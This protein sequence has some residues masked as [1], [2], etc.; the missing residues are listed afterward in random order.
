MNACSNYDLLTCMSMQERELDS[1][2]RLLWK[3]LAS[4]WQHVVDIY[5]R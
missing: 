4:V 5:L 2:G 3:N 1:Q